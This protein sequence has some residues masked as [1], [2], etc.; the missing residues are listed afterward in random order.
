MTNILRKGKGE[1]KSKVVYMNSKK[2][3]VG[4]A[5]GAQLQSLTSALDGGDWSP[6]Y[7]GLFTFVGRALVPTG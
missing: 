5:A 7:I 6:S 2:A 4:V 1:G 3:Y